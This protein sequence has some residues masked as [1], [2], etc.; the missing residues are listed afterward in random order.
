MLI[1]SYFTG[2]N[3]M[4]SSNNPNLPGFNPQNIGYLRNRQNTKTNYT[5]QGAKR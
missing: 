3:I 5:A 4:C 1:K 2:C